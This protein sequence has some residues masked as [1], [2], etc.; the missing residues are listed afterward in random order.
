VIEE[1]K[2]KDQL[3]Q[4]GEEFNKKDGRNV[5]DSQHE[6]TSVGSKVRSEMNFKTVDNRS[7]QSAMAH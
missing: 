6:A 7:N 5:R 2:I 1:Q 3:R 4:I